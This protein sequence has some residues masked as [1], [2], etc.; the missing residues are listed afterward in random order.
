[1]KL[2]TILTT[3]V[4]ILAIATT[5]TFAGGFGNNSN[6][7]TYKSTGTAQAPS[8]SGANPCA[9]GVGLGFNGVKQLSAGFTYAGRKCVVMR[10]ADAL[11]AMLGGGE[12]GKRAWVTHV[13]NNDKRLRRTLKTLGIVAPK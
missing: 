8:M 2:T 6:N 3:T 11:H 10:E 13:A 9:L 12:A 4:A 5:A 1:M 7:S